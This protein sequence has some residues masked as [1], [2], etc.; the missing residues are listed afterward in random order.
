MLA[1]EDRPATHAGVMEVSPAA[2]SPAPAPAPPP[3]LAPPV[4]QKVL[5][6][7]GDYV[8]SSEDD[9][10]GTGT[11]AELEDDGWDLVASKKKSSSRPNS[12]WCSF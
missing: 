12:I 7:E 5:K 11:A 8:S 9:A 10:S 1:P 3:A 2:S 6:Y 4:E